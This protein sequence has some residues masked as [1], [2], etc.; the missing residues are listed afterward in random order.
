MSR[1]PQ[2][3]DTLAVGLVGAG[4]MGQTHGRGWLDNAPRGRIVAVA[5]SSGERAADLSARFA[6]GQAR[7]YPDLEALLGDPEV[8]AVDICLPHHLHKDAIVAAAAAGK[9]VLCEKP[10]CLTLDEARQI[11]EAIDRTGVTFM[12]A[13][14]NLFAP[15]LVAARRL[16]AEGSLG[17]V[18]FARSTE[19]GRNANFK[20]GAPPIELAPGDSSWSWRR[21]PAKAGGGEVLDTGW[22]GAYRLLAL[23][24]SRPVEVAAMLA[25]YFIGQPGVEDTGAVL[26]RFENGAT[27]FLFTS[28]AF[29]DPPGAYQFQVG[30]EH[31]VLGGTS[32]RLLVA[33]FGSQAEEQTFPPAN[34]FA[35]EITHFL[36]VVQHGAPPLASWAD[37]ARVLQLILGAYQA[38][39]ERRTVTLPQDPTTLS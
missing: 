12:S 36:D 2:R 26:V 37:A 16:L 11:R 22:H 28:W 23:A 1:T 19:A 34:T 38:A 20:S 32:T 13:H 33:R 24:G 35:Q 29:G 7:T 3:S 6:A 31:G 10:L 15:A 17:A 9:H 14:N 39:A 8:E 4:W 30:A 5:D 25:D 21:D 27:G 18:H